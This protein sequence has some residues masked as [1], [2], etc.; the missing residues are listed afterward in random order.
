MDSVTKK[1]LIIAFF[2]SFFAVGIPYW[3]IPYNTVNLPEAL[4]VFGLIVVGS[5]AMMLRLQTTATFWQI[6]KVITASVPAAVFARVVWDG[7]KDPSSHNLWPFEIAV[8][9]PVGFACAFTGALAGSLIAAMTGA[10]EQCRK[11]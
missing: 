2:L 5:A 4:P 9:L 8:V 1:H 11:R 6:I 3:R 7:F 10:P